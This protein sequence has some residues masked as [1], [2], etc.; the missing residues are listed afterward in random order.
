MRIYGFK[1]LID[2]IYK[3]HI[4]NGFGVDELVVWEREMG[5]GYEM[6][7]GKGSG[8]GLEAGREKAFLNHESYVRNF[9]INPKLFLIAIWVMLKWFSLD[10][11]KSEIV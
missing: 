6:V 10:P 5:N 9:A 2:K 1:L 11:I 8:R 7:T 4:L 3:N